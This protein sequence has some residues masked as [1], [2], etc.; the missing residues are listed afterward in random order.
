MNIEALQYYHRLRRAG[1]QYA[2][3]RNSTLFV[4]SSGFAD[5]AKRMQRYLKHILIYPETMEFGIDEF[6]DQKQ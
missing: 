1:F 3:A 4:Y 6:V 2:T 5:L